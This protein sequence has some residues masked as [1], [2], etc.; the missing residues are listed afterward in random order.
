[1]PDCLRKTFSYL[2]KMFD[3]LFNWLF[4][5]FRLLPYAA[6]LLIV[7]WLAL[8][9]GHRTSG[10]PTAAAASHFTAG[11]L[12]TENDLKPIDLDRLVNKYLQVEVV[13]HQAVTPE[14]VSVYPVLDQP[15]TALAAI[16]HLKKDAVPADIKIG[17]Q[18][19]ICSNKKSFGTAAT[20]AA[21]ACDDNSCAFTL[22]LPKMSA[23]ID[24]T[25][26]E[27]ATLIAATPP[28]TCENPT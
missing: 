1:M 26:L 10:G 19:Q 8:H 21:M 12:L 9:L 23:P 3:R 6:Y 24:A 16:L 20:V 5:R 15:V 2:Y 13:E 4:E 22:I 11:H 28:K 25:P 17:S 27:T 14:M 18:V 7:G